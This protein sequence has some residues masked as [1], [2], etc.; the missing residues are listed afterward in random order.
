M[1]LSFIFL[2]LLY[3]LSSSIGAVLIKKQLENFT[4]SIEFFKGIYKNFTL[5]IAILLNII[6]PLIILIYLIQYIDVSILH[7]S[8]SITYVFAYIISIIYYKENF[9]LTGFLGVLFMITGI[10]IFSMVGT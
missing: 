6:I 7:P 1:N 2:V 5:Q 10:F 8:L 4:I 9:T 3:G